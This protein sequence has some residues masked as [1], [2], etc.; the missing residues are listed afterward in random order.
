[1][2]D[3]LG[4]YTGTAVTMLSAGHFVA[5]PRLTVEDYWR[6]TDIETVLCPE[7][8]QPALIRG[9]VMICDGHDQPVMWRWPGVVGMD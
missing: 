3:T 8:N 4:A 2:R 9:D 6:L 1:M 5:L 7:C